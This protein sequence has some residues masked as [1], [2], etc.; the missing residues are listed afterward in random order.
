MSVPSC[1]TCVPRGRIRDLILAELPFGRFNFDLKNRPLLVY[2]T[3]LHRGSLHELSGSEM[4]TCFDE[5]DCF[6]KRIQLP[7]YQIQVSFGSWLNH[8][9][10]HLKIRADETSI[11]TL[12]YDALRAPLQCGGPPLRTVRSDVTRVASPASWP[13]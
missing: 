9:H 11:M 4:K 7:D 2:T 6:M 8:G 5:I 10:L 13:L 3:L 12:R 1:Y